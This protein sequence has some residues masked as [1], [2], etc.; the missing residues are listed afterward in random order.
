MAVIAL[1]WA[2]VAVFG[3]LYATLLLPRALEGRLL[4]IVL[5]VFVAM[6]LVSFVV[7]AVTFSR[8]VLTG[9]YPTR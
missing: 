9:A 2:F 1:P 3:A 5:A 4:A 7:A 8:D 6:V